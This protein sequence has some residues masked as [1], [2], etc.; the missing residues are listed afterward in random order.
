MNFERKLSKENREIYSCLKPFA[1]FMEEN[2]FNDIFEGFVLE[3]N[4]RQRLNQLKQYKEM[5]LKTYDDIEKYLECETRNKKDDKKNIQTFENEGLRNSLDKFLSKNS[6]SGKLAL[7]NEFEENLMRFTGLEKNELENYKK[8][9]Y[10]E[11]QN[12]SSIY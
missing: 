9:L 2:Q 3:K 1:R 12:H 4:L 6:V 10:K 5:G 11:Y 7:E 8:E